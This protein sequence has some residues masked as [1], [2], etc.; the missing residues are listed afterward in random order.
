MQD[1]EQKKSGL[2]LLS[3]IWTEW[4]STFIFLFLLLI[5]WIIGTGEMI[6]GQLLRMGE[7]LYG[8]YYGRCFYF[9]YGL[10]DEASNR[11][12]PVG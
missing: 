6:H 11:S 1:D 12:G 10:S 7:L 2:G 8:D 4:I 5:R 9:L 3:N